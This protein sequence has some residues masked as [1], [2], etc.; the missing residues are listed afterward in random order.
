MYF[1]VQEEWFLG[2]G[3]AYFCSGA[4]SPGFRWASSPVFEVGGGPNALSVKMYQYQLAMR[5][6]TDRMDWNRFVPMPYTD[7]T[8]QAEDGRALRFQA[9]ISED[10]ARMIG[11][12]FDSYGATVPVRARASLSSLGRGTHRIAW[13]D[14]RTGAELQTKTAKGPNVTTLSPAFL[15]HAVLMVSPAR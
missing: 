9:I 14:D 11:W 7:M 6:I 10:G 15:G 4:A 2:L 5:R 12:I 8:V 3:W 1:A 13:Y